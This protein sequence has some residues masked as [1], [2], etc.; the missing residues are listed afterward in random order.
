MIEVVGLTK[1]FGPHRAI[2]DVTVT[3]PA[4]SVTALLGL[5]GAGK[6]TLLRVLTGLTRP[7]SGTISVCGR[8]PG[9]DPRVLGFHLGPT[10]MDPRHT[11]QR[12][13]SWLAA[14][15]GIDGARLDEV[16]GEADLRAYRSTRI[17]RL[18]LGLRQRVAI[19]ATLLA[20]PQ[21]LL[22]DEPL[23]GLDVPG[24]VWFRSLLRRLADQGRTVVVATHLLGEV[25]LTSDHVAVLSHGRMQA[26]G[27]LAQLTPTGADTR[28]WL[29]ATL[30]ECA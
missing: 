12:H 22:F 23:N 18:S 1:S 13:L 19:A 14:L 7:D 21:T 20:D 9:H 15:S 8:R 10:A 28:E 30:L 26:A 24:I 29:E 2:D 27:A 3:F 4:G 17:D 16:L 5:N 6:T 25:A 11:V